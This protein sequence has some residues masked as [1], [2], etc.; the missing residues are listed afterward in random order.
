MISIPFTLEGQFLNRPNRFI[1]NCLIEGKEEVAY[2]P[3]P[4][5]MWELLYPGV[6]L[7]LAENKTGQTPYTVMAVKRQGQWILAHTT[8]TNQITAELLKR[9]CLPGLEEARIV[10]AE[11]PC[12]H[13]RFDFLLE[14]DGKPFW[15]EVKSVTLFEEELAMFP[16][17]VTDRGRKHLETL[18]SLSQSGE[19]C[20]VAFMIHWSGARYFL[21]D[22]HTDFAFAQTFQS[23]R[24]QIQLFPYVL[25]WQGDLTLSEQVGVAQIPWTLL[26]QECRNEGDYFF[27]FELPAEKIISIGKLGPVTFRPGYYIYV[28]SARKNLTQRLNRHLHKRKKK[29]WHIDYLREQ[30]ISCKALPIR[31]STPLEHDLAKALSSLADWSVPSFG[32]SDCDCMS[33][34]FGF[35]QDPLHNQAFIEVLQ[36]FR[37]KRLITEIQNER[38]V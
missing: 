15:L 22:Y 11:A 20:G 5:R 29:H 31:S 17:A 6:S 4:G 30:A 13:H 9:K 26:E 35:V 7:A 2:L 33:H 16:D 19:N 10:R 27:L 24:E 37:M 25:N 34:L 21:P 28:G 38:R 3:N 12:G 14:K 8:K 32:S 36:R 1:V 18:A 23:V